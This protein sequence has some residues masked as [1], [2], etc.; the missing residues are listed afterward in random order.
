MIISDTKFI[1]ICFLI[2]TISILALGFITSNLE[3]ENIAIIKKINQNSRFLNITIQ[4]DQDIY[5]ATAFTNEP[6]NIEQGDYISIKG[7]IKNNNIQLKKITKLT[8]LSQ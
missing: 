2:F 8:I 7:T 6:L 5:E 1:K 4:I 3:K